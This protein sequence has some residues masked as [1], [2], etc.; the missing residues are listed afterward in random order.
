MAQIDF[1]SQLNGSTVAFNPSAD[2]LVINSTDAAGVVLVPFNGDLIVGLST[3]PNKG[4]GILLDGLSFA[5]VVFEGSTFLFPNDG[6]EFYIDKGAD[7]GHSITGTGSV[8]QILGLSGNDSMTGLGG[9][10]LFTL[11]TGA[12]GE[13]G[14]DTID[15]GS[16]G[17]DTGID[18]I[19]FGTTADRAASVNLAT[20]VVTGGNANSGA[21]IRFRSIDNA[22]GTG[23]DDTLTGNGGANSFLGF[24]GD[25]SLNGA[26]GKDLL[27]GARGNDTLIGGSGVDTAD[28][29]NP[30]SNVPP[31]GGVSLSL[32]AG[33][34]TDSWGDSDQLIAI[35][36][37]IGSALNDSIAGSNAGNRL[38]GRAGDDSLAGGA[39]GDLL[40]G[41]DGNDSLDGGPGVDTL[42]GG[43]GSDVLVA[44]QAGD[45]ASGLGVPLIVT[46]GFLQSDSDGDGI[47]DLLEDRN[48]NDA[49]DDDDTDNDGIADYLDV[50]SDD[51]GALDSNES[52]TEDADND[53]TPDRF[54]PDFFGVRGGLDAN[55]DGM[56]DVQETG[57]GVD[58]VLAGV[59]Y[60]LGE[61][62]YN[63]SLTGTAGSAGT[64]NGLD[65]V[66][67]GNAGANAL[68][69]GQGHDQLYGRGGN[70]SL[71]GGADADRFV[72]DRAPDAAGNA[73][74]IIDFSHADGDRIWLDRDIFTRLGAASGVATDL[75]AG[76]F[77]IVGDAHDKDTN[78]YII[79]NPANGALSYDQDGSGTAFAAVRFATLANH[80]TLVASDLQFLVLD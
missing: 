17:T 2:Q 64:G 26:G 1:E 37:V 40:I 77:D 35:E 61:D 72:F 67:T 65:N 66:L 12:D 52:D 15:G 4:M 24:D 56:I 75:S 58:T 47:I 7:A 30:Y 23:F 60:T 79:Y 70:D 41:G 10:D 71:T 49:V 20:G 36:N 19:G 57:S 33:T 69:G 80:P 53:G 48:G 54:D 43:L 34:A 16:G 68:A 27:N 13:Y 76:K 46:S 62:I 39:G 44:G 6:G 18:A 3:G 25:D 8:D 29:S 32:L 22:T 9:D 74:R 14:H 63:L 78:D 31:T 50:N 28:Y 55:G 51:D 11:Q 38:E 59:S 45:V 73:D 21:T 42:R 5:G